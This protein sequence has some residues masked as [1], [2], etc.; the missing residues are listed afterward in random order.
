MSLCTSSL[1]DSFVS[2]LALF[3]RAQ[4]LFATKEYELAKADVA[5][6]LKLLPESKDFKGL[7]VKV[8]LHFLCLD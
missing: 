1:S 5:K 4:A 8:T 2:S 3:R 6:G 7:Q